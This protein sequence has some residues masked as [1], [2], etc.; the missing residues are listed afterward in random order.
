[1][2]SACLVVLL[3]TALGGQ[4]MAAQPMSR[5][6]HMKACAD[7]WKTKKSNAHG[8]RYQ[9]FMSECMKSIAGKI[10]AHA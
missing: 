4:A 8:L 1:M 3:L 7:Q 5:P 9:N 2:R 10:P 6:E